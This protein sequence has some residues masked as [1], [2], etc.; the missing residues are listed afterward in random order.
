VRLT[1]RL[2][3]EFSEESGGGPAPDSR[4]AGQDRPKRVRMYQ[5]P[6][7]A[8]NL[9]ALLV[10]GIELVG[11]TGHDDGRGL[12]TRY[13]R[14]LFAECLND[15]G[16]TGCVHTRGEFGESVGEGLL[17]GCDKLSGRRVSLK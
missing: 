1:R 6:D 14:C 10:Q 13:D 11:Q 4:H 5:T 17:A 7:F 12:C 8:G 2:V 9:V 3:S 16:R 15:F